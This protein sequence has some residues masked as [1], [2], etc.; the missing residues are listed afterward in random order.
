[1]AEA[2]VE[3]REASS[4]EPSAGPGAPEADVGALLLL[5]Q[6]LADLLLDVRVPAV[7]AIR[8]ARGMTLNV[9]DVL[10][11]LHAANRGRGA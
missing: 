9:V 10:E 2:V 7:Q 6:R 8:L 1:M 3:V 4:S 5:A 11:G